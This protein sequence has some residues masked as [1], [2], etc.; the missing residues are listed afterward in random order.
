VS[1]TIQTTDIY[2]KMWHLIKTL[3]KKELKPQNILLDFE[4]SAHSDALRIFP[5][6]QIKCCRFHIGLA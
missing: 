5:N 2:E 1:V 6:V 3:C 4:L